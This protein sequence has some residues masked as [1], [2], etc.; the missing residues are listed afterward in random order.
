MA[1]N[2][3]NNNIYTICVLMPNPEIDPYWKPC[4]DGIKNAI[5]ELKASHTY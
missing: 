2:L 3:K 5:S 1:R 4:T